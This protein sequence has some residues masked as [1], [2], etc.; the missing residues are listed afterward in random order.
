MLTDFWKDKYPE[1]IPYRIDTQAYSSVLEVFHEA[2]HRF[3]DAP[4]F[5]NMGC[6]LSYSDIDRLSANFAS[7]LQQ[8][9]DLKAGDRIAVQ[10]PNVLQYPVVV[11]GAMRAGLVVVNTNPLYTEREMLHQFNDSGAK[12]LVVLANFGYMAQAVVGQTGIKHVI[13]T[14]LADLL[15]APKRWILNAAVKHVKKMVPAYSLPGSVKLNA[16]L[17]KGR[18]RA[19]VDHTAKPDDLCVL[20]YTGGTTG[21]SK[22]A[23]LTNANLVA[24]LLQIR[25]VLTST[26]EPGKEIMIAPLPLYHIFAFTVCCLGMMELGGHTVLI[27]NPRDIPAFVKELSKWR[28]TA[29]AGLNTLFVGLMNN[30]EF[31]KIDFKSLKLTVAGGMAMQIKPSEEWEEIT[32]CQICEGFGMTETSPVVTLNPLSKIQIGTIGM[33]V[34]STE[35]KVISENGEE[36]PLGEAGEL[37]VRG[38]Q[39]MKGYWQL[40]EATAATITEDGWLKTGDVAVIQPDGYLRIV[41]RIK[42]MILVSGFNVYPNEIEDVAAAHPGVLEA[43]AVGIPDEKSGE[44]VKLFVVRKDPALTEDSLMKHL[45]SNLTG[46]K[47]PRSIVFRADLPKTNVGK[48]L[49]RELRDQ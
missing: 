12:A 11:F 33:P 37:C 8:H 30:P 40:P 31:R 39:V 18:N 26:F 28:F 19:P 14:E 25:A 5:S 45:R 36:L 29:M 17:A 23:M 48:I 41:D 2:C 35:L 42:D 32:G 34:P 15:P 49:R 27:T 9:T 1:N 6:T 4:A 43:A 38:P 3:G 16:A 7:Y 13:V 47:V 46:Y 20:Q 44:V 10:M 24:N 22:G 21:V